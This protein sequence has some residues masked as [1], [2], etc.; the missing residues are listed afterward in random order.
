MGATF[1]ILPDEIMYT[2]E[3]LGHLIPS[4][5]IAPTN[6]LHFESHMFMYLVS[7]WRLED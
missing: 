2:P 3:T 5:V 1:T 7:Y 6:C 4:E